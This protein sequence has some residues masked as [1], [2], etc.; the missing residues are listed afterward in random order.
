[1]KPI[2]SDAMHISINH[3]TRYTYEPE[4]ARAALRLSLHP[5]ATSAQNIIDWNVT[6]NGQ[7]ITPQHTD[8]LGNRISIWTSQ[9]ALNEVEVVATGSVLT[10]D[11][12]GILRGLKQMAPS[13]AFL[14]STELTKVCEEVRELASKLSGDTTLD[15]MHQ[16]SA[17]VEEQVTY[18]KGT[19]TSDTSAGQALRA[20]SGV[21]QDQAHVFI[22]TARELGVPSRYVAGYM[23]NFGEEELSGEASHAWAEV[24]VEGLGWTGFDVTNQICPTESYV[25]LSTGLDASEAAPIRGVVAGELEENM[26]TEVHITPIAASQVQQ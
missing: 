11:T 12:A 7:L 25:R 23:A 16:L 24:W 6:I 4:A 17:A 19:T 13:A 26:E 14:R 21:C 20:G 5:P 10:S 15:L 8:A 2:T 22:A 9:S 3:V 18:R 1:M